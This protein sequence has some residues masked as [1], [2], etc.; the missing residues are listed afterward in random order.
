MMSLAKLLHIPVILDVQF[1]TTIPQI[2]SLMVAFVFANSADP[3]EM[4]H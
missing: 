3:G 1:K 4:Q 2:L